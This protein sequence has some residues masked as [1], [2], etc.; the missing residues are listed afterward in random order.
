MEVREKLKKLRETPTKL[1]IFDMAKFSQFFA[2]LYK[3]KDIPFPRTGEG[4][5]ANEEAANILNDKIS[6]EETFDAVKSLKNGKAAGLDRV[7]NEQLKS[8]VQNEQALSALIKLF[9]GCLDAGVYPWNTTVISPLHKKGCIY[10]PDNYR[11]IA[12]GSNLGKLFSTILLER[13][14]KFREKHCPDTTNQLGFCKHARTVDHLFTLSTCTEKYVKNQGRRLYSCFVDYRKAFDSISRDA[15]LYKLSMLGID[16][17][18]LN[19][20][21]Y[22]YQNSKAKVK[23]ISKLSQDFEIL[24]G[25]EQGHPMSPELFKTY[26]H[27]LS[28]RLNSIEDL[29]CPTLNERVLTHLLW[30]DD[31]VLLALTKESLQRLISELE[32]FC[33]EWGL[34]VNI[35]KTAVMVFNKSGRQLKESFQFLYMGSNIP[36]AK[37]YCYLGI[38]FSISGSFKLAT[39]LLRQKALR[40]YFGLKREVDLQNI[41]KVAVLK[42]IDSLVVPV[43]SYGIEVWGAST[44]GFKAF[45]CESP[46]NLKQ[47][48]LSAI[49]KDACERLQLSILKWTLGVGKNTS[50]VAIWGDSGR[51]PLVVRFVKQIT[52]YLN[53][54]TKFENEDSDKLVRHAFAEQKKLGL[55]WYKNV[56]SLLKILDHN[57]FDHQNYNALLCQERATDRFKGIWEQ[58]RRKNHKLKFYN[59]VKENFGAEPYLKIESSKG[60]NLIAKIRMSAHKL[61]IETGRY[62]TKSESILNR[63]C[64]FCCDLPTLELLMKLPEGDPIIEDEAHFLVSCPRYQNYRENIKEPL[65]SLILTGNCK[66]MFEEEHLSDLSKFLKQI[67][68]MRFP[69]KKKTGLRTQ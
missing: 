46:L 49:S 61:N 17:K 21:R 13:L 22:M 15:L 8:I 30:A 47:P 39:N 18:F 66:G 4:R 51:T 43:I 68:Q 24:A 16:G 11:A 34:T 23:L 40:A 50:N 7:L 59:E 48:I 26:I 3:K 29:D 36:S 45:A 20:L 33:E 55:A 25:T 27:E 38:T 1:D 41:S 28:V 56:D 62:G 63:V 57:K 53:R 42:L 32:A 35:K 12:I 65:S 2:D 67:F 31:L 58:E 44:N 9:N 6:E 10:N 37:T 54:L 52:D 64:N 69:S 60:S 5:P 14:L 19:C